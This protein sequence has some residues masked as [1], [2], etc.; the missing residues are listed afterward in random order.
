MQDS[1]SAKSCR[2]GHLSGGRSRGSF[3]SGDVTP[4]RHNRERSPGGKGVSGACPDIDRRRRSVGAEERVSTRP[5]LPDGEL[6]R[7][8]RRSMVASRGRCPPD[9][10]SCA[11]GGV[12]PDPG[13]VGSR[14]EAPGE[15]GRFPTS[16]YGSR[17]RYPL[18]VP[19]A[20]MAWSVADGESTGGHIKGVE[21]VRRTSARGASCSCSDRRNAS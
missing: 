17:C 11:P 4:F 6:L 8:A 1:R 18:W 7:V 14:M 15:R 16:V 13:S 19:P 2:A 9:Q 12:C 20:R 21:M 3:S 10:V 5:R